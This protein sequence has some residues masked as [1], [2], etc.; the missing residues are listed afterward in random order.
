MSSLTIGSSM[1]WIYFE[2]SCANGSNIT[3]ISWMNLSRHNPPINFY[4][5]YSYPS[6]RTRTHESKKDH[7]NYYSDWDFAGHRQFFPDDRHPGRGPMRVTGF[8]LQELPRNPGPGPG[9]C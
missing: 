4:L 2:V 5:R 8:F 6:P 3:Q 1:L 7:D 9:Q